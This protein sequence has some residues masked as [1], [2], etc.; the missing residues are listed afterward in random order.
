MLGY[1]KSKN[2]DLYE[3]KRLVLDEII[4]NEKIMT[5]INDG[6]YMDKMLSNLKMLDNLDYNSLEYQEIYQDVISVEEYKNS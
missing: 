4:K 1:P 3:D 6:I 5:H 2:G